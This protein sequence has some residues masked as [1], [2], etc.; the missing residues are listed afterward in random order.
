[1]AV[2][3]PEDRDEGVGPDDPAIDPRGSGATIA[4][5]PQAAASAAA[6][7]VM[8]AAA[9]GRAGWL[10]RV[11]GSLDFFRLWLAQVVQAMGDWVGLLAISFLA[12]E[13]GGDQGSAAIGLVITARVLPG[14]FLAPLAGVMVD[15]WDRKKVLV[16]CNIGRAGVVVL[17]PFVGN[18]AW[19]VVAAL[20]L[21]TM[22]L[23]WGPAKEA[24]VPNLVPRDHLTSA[25]S[26]GLAAAYG[27]FP[28]ASVVFALLATVSGVLAG[29]G[30]FSFLP[31]DQVAVAFYFQALA[32]LV[33]AWLISRLAIPRRERPT[34]SAGWGR[35]DWASTFRDLKEGWQY[36]FLNPTVRA[37]NIGLATGL[38]GGGM[39]I[40]LGVTFSGDVLDAGAAGYGLF[41]TALGF[42]VAVGVVVISVVQRRVNQK[43]FFSSSLLVAGAALFVAASSSTLAVSV[44]L[45]FVMGAAVG[46]VYVLGYATLQREVSDDLR[47]RVFGALNTLVRLCLI[48]SMSIGPLLATVLGR[49]DD[50]TN[51]RTLDLGGITI[52]LPGVRVTLWIASLIIVAAGLMARRT[53]RAGTR[54]HPTTVDNNPASGGR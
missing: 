8:A 37:V 25:N 34:E 48:I 54:R 20:A 51:P 5:D 46:P 36:I 33:S 3:R 19:L 40:P 41:M 39:L 15:R 28:V 11:F 30:A 47:G 32:F 45:V 35:I 10:V 44:T 14:L 7:A 1:V 50:A 4:P 43:A 21:E 6:D 9:R 13:V 12:G 27:T 38:I 31:T 24:T 29:I 17:L 26:L 53:L 42:G 23:L 2:L 18:L 49:S 16:I 52:S 22:T